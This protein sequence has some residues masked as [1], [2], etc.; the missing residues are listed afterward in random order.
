M[1]EIIQMIILRD[2]VNVA[3]YFFAH[4][5]KT[6]KSSDRFKLAQTPLCNSFFV[7]HLV[8]RLNL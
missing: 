7:S 5:I 4:N 6:A 2:Y 8:S 1:R 3:E